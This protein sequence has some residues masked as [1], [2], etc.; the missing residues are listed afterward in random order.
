MKGFHAT[1]NGH[2]FLIKH[3]GWFHYGGFEVYPYSCRL[4]R[5]AQKAVRWSM[6]RRNPNGER[7]VVGSIFILDRNFNTSCWWKD[8][9]RHYGWSVGGLLPFISQFWGFLAKDAVYRSCVVI[10]FTWFWCRTLATRR[11]CWE[12]LGKVFIYGCSI[13]RAGEPLALD[14]RN[15]EPSW[16]F[17]W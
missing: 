7:T 9:F 11:E 14:T 15:S 5:K 10:C 16:L 6:I 13:S 17:P 8:I 1:F 2:K 12:A 4:G 3:R